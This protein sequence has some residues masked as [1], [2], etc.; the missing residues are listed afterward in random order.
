MQ[1]L[2]TAGSRAMKLIFQF[3]DKARLE[4]EAEK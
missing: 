2:L 1:V 3:S 4:S